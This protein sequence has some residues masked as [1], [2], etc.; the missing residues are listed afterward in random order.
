MERISETIKNSVLYRSSKVLSKSD[1][2]KLFAVVVIQIMLG[3]LDLVGVGL[4]GVIG[5]LAI[6]GV[7]SRQPGN[8]VQWLLDQLNLGSYDLQKQATILGILA[9][10]VMV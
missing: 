6:S 5:S 1:K 4:I 8:R 2:R 10:A 7:G 9:V 3:V